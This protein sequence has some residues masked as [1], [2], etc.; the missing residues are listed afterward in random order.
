MKLLLHQPGTRRLRVAWLEGAA[1][2]L[3]LAGEARALQK[4]GS[5]ISNVSFGCSEP[6]RKAVLQLWVGFMEAF[7]GIWFINQ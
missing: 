2:D 6:G 5:N 3:G 7:E 1:K 4:S